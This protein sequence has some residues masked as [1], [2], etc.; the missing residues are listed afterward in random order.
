[1]NH[2]EKTRNMPLTNPVVGRVTPCAPSL[3]AQL[4][5]ER[6][7][8]FLEKNFRKGG[9]VPAGTPRQTRVLPRLFRKFLLKNSIFPE[10]TNQSAAGDEH[11]KGKLW[12]L[13]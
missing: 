2:P 6:S 4:V 7:G 13:N 8:L 5:C 10:N 1:M 3:P 11:C 12:P 9:G